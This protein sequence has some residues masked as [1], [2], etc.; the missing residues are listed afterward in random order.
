MAT[1][2]GK[3]TTSRWKAKKELWARHTEYTGQKL[4]WESNIS[5]RTLPQNKLLHPCDSHS[6]YQLEGS[7]SQ[8]EIEIQEH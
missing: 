8:S 4:V 5:A 2:C 6:L 7:R 1:A 3:S